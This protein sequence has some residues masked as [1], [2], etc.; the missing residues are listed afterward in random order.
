MT[1]FRLI[2]ILLFLDA[3]PLV[4]AAQE[5]SA[6]PVDTTALAKA[7]QNP[8]GDLISLPFQFNF[9]TAG[10]LGDRTFFNRNFQPVITA[11]WD[12]PSG[13]QWTVPIGL[14]VS[15]TTVFNGRPMS[16]GI[17]Y[18]CNVE[19]PDGTAASLLRITVSLLYPTRKGA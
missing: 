4:A 12:A 19:R 16:L 7:T 9:N 6:Q 1:T 17:Q 5:A 11:N 10:D 3:I 2:A 14:G 8:V 15:R 18:Y 13:Q